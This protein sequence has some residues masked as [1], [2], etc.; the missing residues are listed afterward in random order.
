MR[1]LDFAGFCHLSTS[2][3]PKGFFFVGAAFRARRRKIINPDATAAAAAEALAGFFEIR[4]FV[5][6]RHGLAIV[7]EPAKQ[8]PARA[9]FV[10]RKSEVV[11]AAIVAFAARVTRR[12]CSETVECVLDVVVHKFLYL[13]KIRM[14]GVAG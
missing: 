2:R 4:R 5:R 13:L 12:I 11:F 7:V 8:T 10:G 1:P 3:F 6:E 9:E 14:R